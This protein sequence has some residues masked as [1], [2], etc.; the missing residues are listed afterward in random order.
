MQQLVAIH[1][2]TMTQ[3]SWQLLEKEKTK[4]KKNNKENRQ[5]YL[6]EECSEKQIHFSFLRIK[7]AVIFPTQH[8]KN[9]T[10]Y[11]LTILSPGKLYS[12]Q[13]T[14]QNRPLK[15]EANM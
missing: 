1:V 15:V 9:M 12:R 2:F 6:R 10:E 14:T 5:F 3:A 13:Q 8:T 4:Q 11:V 7:P